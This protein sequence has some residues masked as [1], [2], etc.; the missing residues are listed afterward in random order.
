M[1]KEKFYKLVETEAQKLHKLLV[2]TDPV[3]WP[4][5]VKCTIGMAY[6]EVFPNVVFHRES[7]DIEDLRKKVFKDNKME[8]LDWRTE[9]TSFY[10][11]GIKNFDIFVE[12]Y[13]KTHSDVKL[14]HI[15]KPFQ[16]TN[17]IAD[18]LYFEYIIA[19]E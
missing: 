9:L 2:D 6:D 19:F 14:I 15:L 13:L 17:R 7:I 12:S 18:R 8:H 1:R 4:N 5:N 10:L 16:C 3:L 11:R